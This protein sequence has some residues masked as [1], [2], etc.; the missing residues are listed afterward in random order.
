[1]Q[2]VSHASLSSSEWSEAC[3][4]LS[5]LENPTVAGDSIQSPNHVLISMTNGPAATSQQGELCIAERS[6]GAL[7]VTP[8]DHLDFIKH[9]P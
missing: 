7:E 4:A 6:S 5:Q 8:V 9:L 2:P 1:M 3:K